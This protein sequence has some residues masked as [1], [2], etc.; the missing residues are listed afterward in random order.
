LKFL[1]PLSLG[2]LTVFCAALTINV[3]EGE[4]RAAAAIPEREALVRYP[5]EELLARR[6]CGRHRLMY[7]WLEDPRKAGAMMHARCAGQIK[8]DIEVKF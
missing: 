1:P 8:V 6:A 3:V 5:D 2:V 7:W 4:L